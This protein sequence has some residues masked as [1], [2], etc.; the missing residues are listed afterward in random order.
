MKEASN[1]L[2]EGKDGEIGVSSEPLSVGPDQSLA[3]DYELY[4]VIK[5]VFI[6]YSKQWAG[7]YLKYLIS[8]LVR[9]SKINS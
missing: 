4:T 7:Y 9:I 8:C 3:A 6:I 1:F 2:V 5:S